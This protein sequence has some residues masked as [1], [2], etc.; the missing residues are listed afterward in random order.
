[1]HNLALSYGHFG[2]HDDALNLLGRT[3]AL[4]KAKLGPDHIDTLRSMNSLAG[5][6]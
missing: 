2:R 6:Y 3:L 1:M 5:S 4:Q